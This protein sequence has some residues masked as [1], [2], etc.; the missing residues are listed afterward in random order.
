MQMILPRYFAVLGHDP[1]HFHS[2]AEGH[3]KQPDSSRGRSVALL[4]IVLLRSGARET[5][6]AVSVGRG[7]GMRAGEGRG[8]EGSSH[9]VRTAGRR[10]DII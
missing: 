8:R 6:T 9:Y 3:P 10:G 5:G 7:W 4:R 1:V 2:L